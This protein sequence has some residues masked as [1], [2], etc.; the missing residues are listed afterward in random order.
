MLAAYCI[1]SFALLAQPQSKAMLD[2]QIN[3]I[4]IK[5]KVPSIAYAIIEPG[6]PHHIKVFGKANIEKSTPATT[7][8]QYRIG[9]VSK[10]LVGIAALQL[11]EQNKLSLDDTLSELLPNF[12]YTNPWSETHPIRLVHLLENT[13]GWNEISLAEF[14]YKNDPPLP[15]SETFE[16]NP[17]SRSSRWPPGTRYAYTNTASTVVAL[18]I[19]KVTGQNFETYVNNHILVPLGMNNT[20]YH[21]VLS[22]QLATGYQ[23]KKAV[24]YKHILMRPAGAVSSTITDMSKLL[25]LYINQNS[26][27]ISNRMLNRM[28]YSHSTNVG[29]FDA[30]YGITNA[31][32][33]YNGI[34]YRGHDGS[35]PGWLSEFVYSPELKTGFVLLQNSKNVRAIKEI[36]FLIS[37]SLEKYSDVKAENAQSISP[38]VIAHSGYYQYINPRIQNRFFL[39]KL[40]ASHKLTIN[41]NGAN[42]KQVFPIGWHRELTLNDS[43]D[44]QNSKGYTVMKTAKDPLIGDVFHYGDRVFKPF[45]A[46]SAWADKVILLLWIILLLVMCIYSLVWPIQV[47][48]QKLNNSHAIK[49]RKTNTLAALSSV[50]FLLFLALGLMSPIAR[51]GTVSF[52]S[53]GLMLTSVLMLLST[54][55]SIYGLYHLKAQLERKVLF[56]VSVIFIILQSAVVCYLAWHGVI[57]MRSWT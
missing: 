55:Y 36:A 44:W 52:F 16:I 25:N 8:T 53:I 12:S 37:K 15:L 30:G 43:G 10:V 34:K 14:A 21:A 9:S 49:L 50:A 46:I 7:S 33:Y 28:G 3:E 11:I 23:G 41:K 38:N 29:E 54:L 40:V 39:E 31:S 4:L 17:N 2:K 45:S 47:K 51:L 27:V 42:F 26:S 24:P 13:T 20:S 22:K 1:S 18:I 57:G 5:H 6:K 32:R 48:R 35:L 56:T 19:E